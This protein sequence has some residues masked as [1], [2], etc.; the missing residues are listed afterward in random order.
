[1]VI[2]LHCDTILR[3]YEQDDKKLLSNDHHVDLNKL[4]KGNVLAQ[5]FAFFINRKAIPK[6]VSPYNYF[7]KI[8]DFFYDILDENKEYI[9]VATDYDTYKKNQCNRKISAFLTIEGGDAIADSL[10][11]L[12]DAYDKGI[13][14]MT[15]TWNYP[16]AIGYP[17]L[18]E[19]Y[20]KS[21]LTN[22]GKSVIEEMNNLGML[23]D[24][25]HLSDQGFYDVAERSKVPF[26]ASHSNARTIK[27]N[28]RNMTDDMIR[29]LANKGG[30]LGINFFAPFLGDSSKSRV[31][32]I[33]KH[34]QHIKKI[35]GIEVLALGSDF[36]G[37]ECE[38]EIDNISKIELLRDA[39]KKQG[40]SE[41]ELDL[42]MYKNT[43]RILKTL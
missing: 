20:M 39:L 1:M 25:S 18:T 22:F 37:I 24:V 40:F 34:I 29:V 14:L 23:I 10:D 16:N 12:R 2:D 9:R 41:N 21:G 7:T 26:V 8:Y 32:D 35:G 33:V 17:N 28:P 3:L 43:E 13:R 5:F 11:N 42:I 6:H 15:L 30:I 27:K 36:D 38:L 31:E 4:D 19:S